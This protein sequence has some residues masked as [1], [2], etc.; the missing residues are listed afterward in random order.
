MMEWIVLKELILIKE[1]HQKCAIF[2]NTGIFS[3][4]GLTFNHLYVI[5]DIIYK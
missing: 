4:K 2:V 5:N 3:S 1:V